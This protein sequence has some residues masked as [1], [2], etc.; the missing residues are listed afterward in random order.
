[1]NQEG[2]FILLEPDD[3][4]WM[5]FIHT[6]AEANVFHHP[7]WMEL[8]QDCYGYTTTILSIPDNNGNLRAGLPFTKVNSPL[9]GRRWVSLSFSD[10]CNPLYRDEAALNDLTCQL[11]KLY[12]S[13]P[14][15]K[16][17]IRWI[18]PGRQEIQQSSEFVLH[19]IKL[20]PDPAKI[21]KSFKRTHLQNIRTA[22]ER[23]VTVRFG[24]RL[25][26]LAAYYELQLET[27]K[28]H[29]VPAQPWKYFENLWRHII[30]AGMGFVL[31]AGH[32]NETIAGMVYLGWGKTLIA[33]YAASREDHF[34]LRPN[35][36]LF[37]E[38][39]RWGCEHG[40]EVF[41]M[42]RTEVENTGLRNFK[43]RWGAVE[44]PLYYSILSSKPLKPSGGKLDHLMHSVIQHSPLWVCRVSGELLYKHVG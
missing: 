12:Q 23:G 34:N 33:K 24:D 21:S 29:G 16:M 13:H 37:W 19:T 3:P 43:S 9:T 41:D 26:D 17:E 25:E 18:L 8:M 42:G 6:C 36:L 15:Q 38:G 22:E 27:R 11:V 4:R 39:I 28:R 10:Y 5:D 7:A 40:F 30:R 2:Q 44:E 32:E 14:S 35:N 31:L 1:M 20:D